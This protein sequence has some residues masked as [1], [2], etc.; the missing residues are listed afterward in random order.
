MGSGSLTNSWGATPAA[1][2]GLTLVHSSAQL[3]PCLSQEY[4]LHTLNT[5]QHP[6]NTGYTTPTRTPYPVQSAQ[7]ELKSGRCKPLPLA[8]R[9]RGRGPTWCAAAVPDGAGDWSCAL[10]EVLRS[11]ACA[12]ASHLGNVESASECVNGSRCRV[13]SLRPAPRI[14]VDSFL[15]RAWRQKQY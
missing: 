1:C 6:L 7:V 11:R 4:T 10:R 3:E 5:P 15:T 8:R 2:Q 13:A 9:R 12:C 14:S